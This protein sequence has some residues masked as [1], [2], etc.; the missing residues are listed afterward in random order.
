MQRF[1]RL[2]PERC[3]SRLLM[4]ARGTLQTQLYNTSSQHYGPSS[5]HHHTI[6]QLYNTTGQHFSTG[7][8]HFGAPR[9]VC[10]ASV[11]ARARYTH[12]RTLK[13]C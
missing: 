13:R 3:S 12:I 8:Q 9:A 7:G 2:F 6:G 1:Q 4:H 11:H 10:I 5:Q